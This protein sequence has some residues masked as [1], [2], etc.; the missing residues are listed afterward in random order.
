[1]SDVTPVRK[2][3]RVRGWLGKTTKESAGA[4]AQGSAALQTAASQQPDNVPT[5]PVQIPTPITPQSSG[6]SIHFVP[7]VLQGLAADDRSLVQ[8]YIGPNISD[9]IKAAYDAATRQRQVC[10]AKVWSGSEKANK[11]ILWLDRFKTTVDVVANADPI[12]VGLPWAGMR[13]LLEVCSYARFWR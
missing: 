10:E 8:A 1:M 2:R 12:H 3:D 4:P 6:Q 11:V 5:Q 9:T 13:L 7:H